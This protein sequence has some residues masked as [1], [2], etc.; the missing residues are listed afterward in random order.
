MRNYR[1]RR[2]SIIGNNLQGVPTGENKHTHTHPRT[3]TH[4]RHKLLVI[5]AAGVARVTVVA[6]ALQIPGSALCNRTVSQH[7]K[8]STLECFELCQFLSAWNEWTR[9][10]DSSP[11]WPRLG[12]SDTTTSRHVTRPHYTKYNITNIP[13]VTVV[14]MTRNTR[15]EFEVKDG[16]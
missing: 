11:D 5:V 10:A 15:I 6:K 14:L 4:T 2:S 3:H 16:S 1:S 12:R 9:T 8:P 7:C 13:R